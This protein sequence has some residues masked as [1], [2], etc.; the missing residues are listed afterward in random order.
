MKLPTAKRFCP[1]PFEFLEVTTDGSAWVCCEDWL[2]TPIGSFAEGL[3]EVWN[4]PTAQAIRASI[5]DGSF[6][7]CNADT[8]PSLVQQ[9]LPTLE[10]VN[11]SLQVY[12]TH[13]ATQ[14]EAGP[15]TLALSYD[16]S[17]NLKCATCR[18]DYIQLVGEEAAQA[19]H[20][21][22]QVVGRYL[23]TATNLIVTGA[24]DA[25]SSRLFGTFLKTL[26][27]ADF[28]D[29][30]ICI[31]TNGLRFTR[32]AWLDLESAHAA[33]DGVTVSVDAATAETYRLNRGGSWPKLL[34][35]LEFLGSLVGVN[36]L[37]YF[38]M[39]FVVQGNNYREME[40]FVEL[41][42]SLGATVL[43][44]KVLPWEGTLFSSPEQYGSIAIHDPL[45]PEHADFLRTL[46]APVFGAE[47]VDL[48]N[49]AGYR[50]RIA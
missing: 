22:E 31:M 23:S 15:K 30:R 17:C 43:F 26:N 4:S 13:G 38:E 36:E 42:R 50:E 44:Q 7:Y 3:Q 18:T 14:L 27:A 24:G 28:P 19:R 46:A 11:L 32:R 25:L 47:D 9:T 35:N 29:L 1:K 45:H 20:V 10:E 2:P 37:A 5:H 39:S 16:N 40:L 49:L 48:S 6:R 41:S 34:S 33:I 12:L 8:C 21:H